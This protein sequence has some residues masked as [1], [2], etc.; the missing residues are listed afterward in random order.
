[1]FDDLAQMEDSHVGFLE[2]KLARD[3]TE[4]ASVN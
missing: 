2:N 3:T 1:L 4:E